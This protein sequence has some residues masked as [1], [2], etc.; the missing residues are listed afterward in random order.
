MKY[1]IRCNSFDLASRVA[2]E[3]DLRLADWVWL[4]HE[5]I[6]DTIEVYSLETET[7]SRDLPPRSKREEVQRLRDAELI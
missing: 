1:V 7:T 3:K 5:T 6:H 2:A 4:P